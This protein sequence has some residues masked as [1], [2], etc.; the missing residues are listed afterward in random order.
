LH[1]ARVLS[2]LAILPCHN[3][4][5]AAVGAY[6]WRASSEVARLDVGGVY[7]CR[8]VLG[9]AGIGLCVTSLASSAEPILNPADAGPLD[10]TGWDLLSILGYFAAV[11][12][13][14]TP[15]VR[16]AGGWLSL[17]RAGLA[18]TRKSLAVAPPRR[19]G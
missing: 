12:P 2:W 17:R 19:R 16:L 11:L 8:R 18:G 9:G 6:S 13:A 14:C 15:G 7:R 1:Q 3:R 5:Y 10:I 4:R